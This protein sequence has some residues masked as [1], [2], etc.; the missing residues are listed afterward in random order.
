MGSASSFSAIA[1]LF[2]IL[3]GLA[4]TCDATSRVLLRLMC[5]LKHSTMSAWGDD[6]PDPDRLPRRSPPVVVPVPTTPS[7]AVVPT[8]PTPA[9]VPPPN[10]PG[11]GGVPVYPCPRSTG[12]PRKY[13]SKSGLQAA[14]MP[15]D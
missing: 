7:P 3:V 10:K 13:F 4:S 5:P 12:P 9:V 11:H 1:A 8:T 6:C 15:C 2:L 14:R